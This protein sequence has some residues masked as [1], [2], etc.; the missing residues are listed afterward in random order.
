MRP[1]CHALPLC[2]TDAYRLISVVG[3][4]IRTGVKKVLAVRQ[5]YHC[6]KC[7]ECFAVERDLEQRD[8][9]PRPTKCKVRGLHAVCR[10]G[11]Q[12][13]AKGGVPCAVRALC[14]RCAKSWLFSTTGSSVSS[15]D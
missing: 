14:T 11:P 4:V 9:L 1:S 3:T 10:L 6:N 5:S 8:A 2:S 12:P 7:N 15:E 13:L